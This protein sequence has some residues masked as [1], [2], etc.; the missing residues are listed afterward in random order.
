M[1]QE[2][3]TPTGE[4]LVVTMYAEGEVGGCASVL[5]PSPSGYCSLLLFCAGEVVHRKG[6]RLVVRSWSPLLV[7]RVRGKGS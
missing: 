5:L 4:L 6:G 2:G 3:S 7:E 1:H